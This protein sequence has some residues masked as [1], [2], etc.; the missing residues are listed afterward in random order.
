MY[1]VL[2]TYSAP[3]EEIDLLLPDHVEW[4]SRHYDSGEFLVSGRRKPAVGDVIITR[5]MLR[6]KLDAIL[7]TDPL[8][9]RGLVHYEV[10][11]FAATR[12]APN[13]NWV[14]ELIPH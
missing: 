3:R 14:N 5:P 9:Y 10:I 4:L 1:V 12:T 8:S 11:E 2:S 7:S 13:L 6:G